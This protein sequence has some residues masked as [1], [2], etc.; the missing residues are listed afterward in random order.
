MPTP[1][2]QATAVHEA[3]H[4][5]VATVLG[6][7]IR[8][9]TIRAQGTSWDRTTY[10]RILQPSTNPARLERYRQRGASSPSRGLSS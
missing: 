10:G 7:P 1:R 8:H 9:V 2:L 6:V 5:V 3:G 4:C